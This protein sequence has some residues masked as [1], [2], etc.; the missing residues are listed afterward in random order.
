VRDTAAVLWA[1]VRG[2]AV[3]LVA[4]AVATGLLQALGGGVAFGAA[5]ALAALVVLALRVLPRLAPA[6]DPP[7]APRPAPPAGTVTVDVGANTLGQSLA[8]PVHFDRV[9]RPRLVALAED[10]LRRHHGLDPQRHPEA[11]R[12]AAG[13]EL[14]ALLHTPGHPQ[15]AAALAAL[16]TRIEAL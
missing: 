2:G 3:A 4:A 9:L 14:W 7:P 1:V 12:A 8:S 6:A 5:L 10:R 15:S 16:I 11:A 13:E